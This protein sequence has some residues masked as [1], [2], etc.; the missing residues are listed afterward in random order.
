MIPGRPV[1]TGDR[2]MDNWLDL[3]QKNMPQVKLGST[4]RDLTT[5]SGTQS[6]T[7]IG[8]APKIIFVTA[9]INGGAAGHSMGWSN[10]SVHACHQVL[11][12][13]GFGTTAFCIYVTDDGTG[14]SYQT[15]TVSSVNNDGFTLSW[16]KTGTPSNTA[17]VNYLAMR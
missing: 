11:G 15:A 2:L 3:L 9:A 1:S 5:A 16:S 17:T 4:T 7:G 13:S 10:G 8:F 12:S 6:I 14:A